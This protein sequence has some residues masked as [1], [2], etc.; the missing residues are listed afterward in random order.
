MIKKIKKL[1]RNSIQF[2][3]D[4]VDKNQRYITLY[5]ADDVILE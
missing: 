3:Y 1:N 2:L 5:Y 4:C